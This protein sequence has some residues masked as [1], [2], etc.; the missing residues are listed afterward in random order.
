[1]KEEKA[2][3]KE[4]KKKRALSSYNCFMKAELGKV[5]GENPVLMHKEAF[6][7]VAVKWSAMSED[8]KAEYVSV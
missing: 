7:A 3:N 8:Q 6:K 5:K 4:D 1:M 2:K